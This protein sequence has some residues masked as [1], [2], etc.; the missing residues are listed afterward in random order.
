MA[1]IQAAMEYSSAD[2]PD[3]DIAVF[4]AHMGYNPSEIAGQAPEKNCRT[5]RPLARSSTG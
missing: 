5:D 2:G 3:C 4:F 1:G